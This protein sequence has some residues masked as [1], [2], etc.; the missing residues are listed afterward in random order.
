MNRRVLEGDPHSVIEGMIIAAYAIGASQGYI[1]CRAEYPLAVQTLNIGIKQARA[2]G[3]LGENI[4][5]SNF[6]F[7][8]EVRMGAGAYVCGDQ[9]ALMGSIEGKRGEPRPSS[10]PKRPSARACDSEGHPAQQGGGFCHSFARR[11]PSRGRAAGHK[12][13]WRRHPSP[14]RR[15]T[16]LP[17]A[18]RSPRA[19]RAPRPPPAR[20][21]RARRRLS[22]GA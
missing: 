10:S 16:G 3:L 12:A 15:A 2:L 21:T 17:S 7:D 19:P 4:L 6:S 11:R 18:T 8:L 13:P 5:G 20:D 9:T 14:Q 22:S 1:Y